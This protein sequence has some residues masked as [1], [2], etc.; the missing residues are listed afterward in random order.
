MLSINKTSEFSQFILF[1][2]LCYGWAVWASIVSWRGDLWREFYSIIYPFLRNM[3]TEEI[4]MKENNKIPRINN[5]LKL[6]M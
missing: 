4:K 6:K 1:F 3:Q 5:Y 2:W